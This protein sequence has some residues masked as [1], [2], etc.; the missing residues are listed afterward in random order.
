MPSVAAREGRG[1]RAIRALVVLTAMLMLAALL[2]GTAGAQEVPGTGTPTTDDPRVGLAPGLWDAEEASHGFDHVGMFE[3]RDG[4]F[5]N[6]DSASPSVTAAIATANSDLAF[7]GDYAIQGNW[8]GFQIHDISDPTALGSDTLVAEVLCPGGQHDPTVYGDLVF[9]SV[10]DTFSQLDCTVGDIP[11]TEVDEN[12]FRGVRIFDI[13]DIE[14]P[15]QVGGVQTC[16]GSHTHRLVEDLDDPSHVYIYNNGTSPLRHPDEAGLDCKDH[17]LT[18]EPL[19]DQDIKRWQIEVIRVPVDNPGDAEIVNN[20]RLFADGDVINALQN[21]LVCP[22]APDGADDPTANC[23]E[24]QLHP[25]GVRYSPLPN[26]NTCHDITA[27]PEVG[28]AAG[29]CQGNGILIDIS[30]PA[31]PVRIDEH[32]DPNFSYWHSANFSNDGTKVMFTDEWGGGS[33]PRCRA[34][35]R[36]EWGANAIFDIVE[37][38]D[39]TRS[40]DFQS[41]YKM[42]AVQT[43]T[44]NCVAHQA[45]IVPV[46]GRDILVQAW[47]QGGISMFDWTDSSNP[48]EIG[49][50]DRGPI[51]GDALVLGGFWS[52][53]WY[54]GNVFGSEIV[55][56]LDA[57]ELTP[58]DHLSANEIAAANTVRFEQHNPMSLRMIE[59]DASFEV[60]LAY[61]D[62][63]ERAGLTGERLAALDTAIASARDLFT[64]G[65]LE[66]AAG[67]LDAAADDVEAD[68]ADL[69]G[70][71]RALAQSIF[72]GDPTG[73]TDPT[74]TR[75]F[76]PTRVETAVAISQATYEDGEASTVVLARADVEPD[77]LAGTPLAVTADGPLLLSSSTDL[78]EATAAELTRVLPAGAPVHLLGGNAALAPAVEEAITALGFEIV[79][80][81]G[82]T[83]VETALAI[84]ERLE[85]P[86]TL[87]VTTGDNFPDA[88]A[89]GAAAGHVGGAVLL[90][91]SGS[92]HPAVTAYLA[93]NAEADVFAVGGPAA[94]AYPDATRVVGPS[95]EETAVEVAEVFFDDPTVVGIA[96]RDDFPD[97]L[98]G[99]AHIG[100]LG[101]PMLLTPTD[102]LHPAPSAYLCGADIEA[103]FVYGGPAAVNASTVDAIAARLTGEGC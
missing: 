37:G 55:R 18:K 23:E 38:A 8:R 83:R 68:F 44:E 25:S 63:A 87:L 92:A 5:W 51:N 86:D 48:Y 91:P 78:S 103:A 28:L 59:W 62:Q 53:Y 15:V 66:E 26:T 14:N 21:T 52:G 99:G 71:L 1:V 46:P 12:R 100:R 13:S 72:D 98:A 33:G 4:G 22:P 95:R 2:P 6:E 3:K 54:N 81:A 27:Y 47:Y 89:A 16:R 19:T 9:I 70:A 64:A 74:V 102:S 17:P 75:V 97:A 34:T 84:A 35:D 36:L 61:R 39:G 45:N 10:Q 65:D 43:G 29:A 11:L 58:T 90:T 30:D 80:V 96:R 49:Y 50:F 73:P 88:L 57:F 31:N 93:A 67:V 7:T 69:A 76:G 60:V 56:G 85:D 40:L 24:D 77:A 41:Y 94:T 101:G 20:A 32:A 42:P 79:R 82:A